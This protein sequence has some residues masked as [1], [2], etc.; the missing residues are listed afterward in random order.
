MED[1]DFLERFNQFL[2]SIPKSIAYLIMG[3]LILVALMLLA[4]VTC[5]I[6][7]IF[8]AFATQ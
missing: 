6:M 8:R 4:F 1:R 5:I 7:W 2:E 3:I